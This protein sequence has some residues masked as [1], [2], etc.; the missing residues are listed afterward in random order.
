MFVTL[1]ILISIVSVHARGAGKGLGSVSDDPALDPC[2]FRPRTSNVKTICPYP[3]NPPLGLDISQDNGKLGFI[4]VAL[5]IGRLSSILGAV[6]TGM[7][8]GIPPRLRGY[9]NVVLLLLLLFLL[10]LLLF[11]LLFL[12]GGTGS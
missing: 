6:G 2:T 11:L 4:K 12:F 8:L 5:I 1:F 7:K 3:S 9:H 10:L